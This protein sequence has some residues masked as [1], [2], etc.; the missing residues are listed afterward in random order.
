KQIT[1]WDLLTHRGGFA[2]NGPNLDITPE[3]IK[4][5]L[6]AEIIKSAMP[7]YA[8][9]ADT[10]SVYS[11]ICTAILG[12]MI[13]DVSGQGLPDYLHDNFYKPLGMPHTALNV[14]DK[15]PANM[16]VQYQF[17]ENGPAVMRPYPTLSPNLAAAGSTTSTTA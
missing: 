5:P 6:A 1:I 10:V 8:R 11:N 15:P 7:G 3:T 16:I 2:G 12:F 13:E 4:T 17:V 9:P 14:D